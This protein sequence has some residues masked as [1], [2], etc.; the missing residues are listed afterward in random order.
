MAPRAVS[1]NLA[2]VPAWTI[3][4]KSS[5]SGANPAGIGRARSPLGGGSRGVVDPPPGGGPGFVGGPRVRVRGLAGR[6][7]TAGRARLRVR[8]A[9]GVGLVVAEDDLIAG[10]R[11][12]A[13]FELDLMSPRRRGDAAGEI[14]LAQDVGL[15]GGDGQL[16][17]SFAIQDDGDP[18][19]L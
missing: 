13:V 11:A 12:R 15:V 2:M 19:R 1:W 10:I 18:P 6:E 8:P 14:N 4:A 17:E 3:P 7:G 9:A 16:L 5:A